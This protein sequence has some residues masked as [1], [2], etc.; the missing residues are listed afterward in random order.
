MPARDRCLAAPFRSVDSRAIMKTPSPRQC[1][2]PH[3]I[4]PTDTP[5]RP[6][7]RSER[8]QNRKT[9]HPRHQKKD[10][11]V[12]TVRVL[13]HLGF[14]IKHDAARLHRQ[15][16]ALRGADTVAKPPCRLS[17]DHDDAIDATTS[18]SRSLKTLSQDLRDFNTEDLA[19]GHERAQSTERLA[20]APADAQEQHVA[21]GLAQHARDARD[22]RDRVHEHDEPASSKVQVLLQ[23]GVSRGRSEVLLSIYGRG[24]QRDVVSELEPLR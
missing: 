4:A 8:P 20:A 11:E 6:P 3:A 10:T 17:C 18:S 23:L 21:L 16:H 5:R 1:E 14:Y 24:Y 7:T 13:L 2:R 15:F 9:D 19:L 22:V 12:Q